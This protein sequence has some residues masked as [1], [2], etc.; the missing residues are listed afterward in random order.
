MSKDLC[1]ENCCL[2][3]YVDKKESR[4]VDGE[5]FPD[6][7]MCNY[8]VYIQKFKITVIILLW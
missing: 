3:Y 1:S 4:I 5:Y 2:N 8:N 7:I 6:F